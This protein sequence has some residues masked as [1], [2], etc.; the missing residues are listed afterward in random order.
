M[1]VYICMCVYV[2]VHVHG[3]GVC[4]CKHA[5]IHANTS[6]VGRPRVSDWQWVPVPPMPLIAAGFVTE[7]TYGLQQ[8]TEYDGMIAGL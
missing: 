1:C 3:H 7:S 4:M 6:Q 5:W 2:H 8:R